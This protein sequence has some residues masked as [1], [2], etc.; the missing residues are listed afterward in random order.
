MVNIGV[1]MGNAQDEAKAVADY[2]TD[3]IDEDGIRNA[4]VHFG[5]I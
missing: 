1:A 3:R 2:I 5:L 4:L